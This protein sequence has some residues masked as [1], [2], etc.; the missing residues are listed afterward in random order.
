MDFVKNAWYGA[1]LSSEV[2]ES[3]LARRLLGIS[4]VFYRTSDG[5]PVA[6]RNSCP[7]RGYPLEYGKRVGDSIECGY[8][9]FV[10]DCAGTC[11]HVPGQKNVPSKADVQAFP[12]IEAGPFVW[13]WMGDPELA[14][15]DLLPVEELGF[16]DPQ[17][18]FTAGMVPIGAN[19][20]LIVDNLLDLSHEGWVHSS[21]IGGVEIAETPMEVTVHGDRDMVE[22][23]RF[24][25]DIPAPPAFVQYAD[26]RGHIDRTQHFH[27]WAPTIYM[28]NNRAAKPGA[29]VAGRRARIIYLCT[30]EDERNT[31]YF[32][33]GGR[34]IRHDDPTADQEL[35]DRQHALIAED[36]E[37]VER[38]QRRL[39][40]EGPTSEVSVKIDSAGLAGRRMIRQML[41]REQGATDT[42]PATVP[43]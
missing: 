38:I 7:H 42:T 25:A 28:L 24:M 41:D 33:C 19:Y 29:E 8:H 22:A 20:E 43:A 26:E 4:L 23:Y 16:N 12:T 14:D 9:G 11:T 18:R 32:Y 40:V 5:T 17:W 31:H 37:A 21:S 36:A 15:P 30:P 35:H 2:S 10:F 34:L 6:L 27:F 13:V 1:A 39:D 3:I